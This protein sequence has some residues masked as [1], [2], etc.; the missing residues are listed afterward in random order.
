MHRKTIAIYRCLYGADFIQQSIKSIIDY[1]DKIFIFWDDIPWGNVKEVTYKG[2]RIFFPKRFDD[3]LDK[4]RDINTDKIELIY[5]HVEN[6]INQ[7]SHLVNDIIIPDYDKPEDI[8][9]IEVDQVFRKNEIENALHEFRNSNW[10]VAKT[11]QIELWRSI[12]FRIPERPKRT[13]VVF[14]NMDG[15][16][17]LPDTFRQGEPTDYWLNLLHGIYTLDAFVHN[18]G[19]C[20]S[21]Q[22]MFWKHLLALGFSQK[23]GDTQPNENW[24]EDKWLTWDFA[25]NN[26]NLEISRGYESDIPYALRYLRHYQGILP[27]VL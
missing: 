24:F 25:D 8:I 6:N 7:F 12:D 27:E 19:F 4:I 23:I 18:L 11:R 9:I 26:E 2:A 20:V 15:I 17:K 5:D 16:D 10:R 21:E 1:V 14:W 3:I 22:A 13:G